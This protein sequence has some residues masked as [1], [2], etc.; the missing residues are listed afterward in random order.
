[1]R[2]ERVR[3]VARAVDRRLNRRSFLR[4]L[5][6]GIASVFVPA[7]MGSCSGH[8]RVVTGRV[9]GFTVPAGERW[10]ISGRVTSTANVVVEGTLVMRSGDELRFVDVDEST[11]VGG[12]DVVLE[13]DVGLWVMG[14]GVLDAQGDAKVP[15]MRLT[16]AVPAGSSR[17]TLPEDPVGW[18]VGD[19]LAITPTERVWPPDAGFDERTISGIAGRTIGLNR[20]L[21]RAH[22]LVSVGRGITLGAEVLNLT[23]SVVVGGTRL[24]RAHVF[25]RSTSPQVVRFVRFEHVG[26]TKFQG[27]IDQ[28]GG[29]VREKILGRW[30]FH[31]HHCGES[32]RDVVFTG[33]VVEH[34]GSHAFV[35]HDTHGLVWRGCIAHRTAYSQFWWDTP[36]DENGNPSDRTLDVL[37]DRCVASLR[38]STHPE[39]TVPHPDD[40]QAGFGIFGPGLP[41]TSHETGNVMR[42]CVAVGGGGGRDAAGMWWPSGAAATWT[43]EGLNVSHNNR[44]HGTAVWHNNG[45][46]E[47][48]G[49]VAYH[50]G[51][52]G[53]WH[54]AYL[55]D[56]H[57]HDL[58]T[59][60]NI[61]G[62]LK[63]H[64][65]TQ[66]PGV[67]EW[68]AC[69]FDAAGAPHCLESSDHRFSGTAPTR[70]V[71]CEFRNPGVSHVKK[72]EP[73]SAEILEFSDC[74]FSPGKPEFIMGPAPAG[75]EWRV[76]DAQHGSIALTPDERPGSVWNPSWQAFV[77]TV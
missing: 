52:F 41:G 22:P 69:L 25:I 38:S 30:S 55:N 34:G 3:S 49:I 35:A 64:A 39:T 72:L 76:N 68:T 32:Q 12:G 57:M 1:M 33:L 9:A 20:P 6:L 44:S 51:G 53:A 66:G 58:V 46:I 27:L 2:A 42:D 62:A 54:G 7:F 63:L 18:K 14:E 24:G 70:F 50:N 77:R 11:F 26:P 31:L 36:A 48:A 29:E 40:R 10:R 65:L 17:L 13:T 19:R 15:W 47:I 5:G 43:F 4:R 60:A 45:T 28:E 73:T 75:T 61:G 23:R 67:Q 56:Y 37:H 21:A 71:R 74:T 16:T 59:S 8:D